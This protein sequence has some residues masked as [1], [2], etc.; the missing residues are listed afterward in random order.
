MARLRTWQLVASGKAGQVRLFGLDICKEYW[1]ETGKYV[2]VIN[3]KTG[4]YES[5]PVHKIIIE[6]ILQ[7]FAALQIGD[8]EW[9]FYL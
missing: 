7:N 3:P 1:P 2:D 6:D 8:N 5:A 9:A 4:Q